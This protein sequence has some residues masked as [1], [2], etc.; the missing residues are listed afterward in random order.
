MGLQSALSTALTGLTAAETSI[1]VVGNNVANANTVGFKESHVSFATQ[2]LQTQ[3]IGSAPTDATGGTN[4]RQTGLGVKVAEISPEF[5]QGT[6]EI[7]ANPL[8]LAIQGDGFFLVQGSQGETLYTRNGQFKTN[9]RNEIVTINGQRVLGFGVDE[10]FEIQT[11]QIVPI[12]IP[13]GAAAVAQATENV[14]ITGELNPN[15]EVGS[16]PEIIQSSILSDGSKEVPSASATTSTALALPLQTTVAAEVA[17]PAGSVNPGGVYSYRVV[18]VDGDG[19]EGPASQLTNNVTVAGATSSIRLTN[20]P[21]PAVGSGFTGVR[22]YRNDSTVDSVFRRVTTLG[23]GP[24]TYDDGASNASLAA[25]PQISTQGL[26]SGSYSYYVTFYNSINNEES[27]PT[28]RIGPITADATTSPRIRLDNLPIPATADFDGIRIYRNQATDATDFR[29]LAQLTPA[30][31][32]A[33]SA[34]GISYIDSTPDAAIASAAEVNLEGPAISFGLPLVDVVS[35]SESTYTNL[36]VPGELTFAGS[37]G[38]RVLAER[39]LTITP[40]TTVGDLLSFMEDSFG[41]VQDAEEDSFPVANY[42]GD[43][44]G[45]RLQFTSNMGIENALSV[46]LS[47]FQLT[48]TGGSTST[49]PLAFNSSQ[50]GTVNGEGSTTNFIVYDSLGTPVSVRVTTVLESRNSADAR[51]RWIATSADNDPETG[52]STLV[53]TGLIITD[54]EGR[55]VSATDDRVAVDRASSPAASPLEFQLDFTRISGLDSGNNQIQASEQDGFPAG[56]LSSF[57]IT[58][59][60]RIQGLFTNGSSRDLGQIRMARFANNSGLEQR[61]ENL[62]AG[63]VNSGLPIEGDPGSQGIGQIK[64]GAVELS[65]ADIGQNLIELILASTQYRGGAR[66]I[67]AVQQLFDELLALRR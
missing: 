41:I 12:T 33:L 22:I 55:F 27:R 37:K 29:R 16:V 24:T 57:I 42:G 26:A 51:F 18:F 9:S 56:T 31:I 63:G 43:I 60:G 36:F 7:S 32:A 10:N 64:A 21:Q 58:D 3:S 13:L 47:A 49:V 11:T 45:S 20:I 5:T 50:T 48:P 23:V 34:G 38:E 39:S 8:D 15:G 14:T 30:D 65:N 46:D 66:V 59:T 53:G 40:T 44:V 52:V 61:G 1:D 17:V 19:N 67:T 54:G 25:A 28:A 4:P 35:R 6:I 2:F 62:F